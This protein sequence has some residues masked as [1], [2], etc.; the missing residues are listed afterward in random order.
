MNWVFYLI[1]SIILQIN[2]MYITNIT[3]PTLLSFP[4]FQLILEGLFCLICVPFIFSPAIDIPDS[5]LWYHCTYFIDSCICICIDIGQESKKS[6]SDWWLS[7][8]E[9]IAQGLVYS[10]KEAHII[11]MLLLTLCYFWSQ[12][13]L[14]RTIISLV[15]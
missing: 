9:R 4:S 3:Y 6:S 10:H 8:L 14:I 7:F 11:S 15:L 5:N 12:W 13:S 2:D 1:N